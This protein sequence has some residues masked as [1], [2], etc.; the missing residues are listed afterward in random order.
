MNACGKSSAAVACVVLLSTGCSGLLGLDDKTFDGSGGTSGPSTTAA[1]GGAGGTGGTGTA[2]SGGST[3]SG[4][5]G[6]SGGASSGSGGVLAGLLDDEFDF[7]S[8][9]DPAAALG[10]RGW[11]FTR[12][13]EE[14]PAAAPYPS[15]YVESGKLQVALDKTFFWYAGGKG[16]LMYKEITGDFL[17]V[18]DSYSTRLNPSGGVPLDYQSGAGILARDPASAASAMGNQHWLAVDRGANAGVLRVHGTWTRASGAS[19]SLPADVSS[20]DGKVAMC[21]IGEAFAI[22]SKEGGT[23]VD[24]TSLLAPNLVDDLP[25]TLQVGL[26]AYAGAEFPGDSTPAGVLGR[27]DFVHQV[28]PGGDCNPAA[29]Q[30]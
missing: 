19:T 1:S 23:W 13:E 29:H 30:E 20:Q 6:G 18:A 22:W 5:V 24:R 25:A 14:Y 17:V 26:F 2:G 12:G 28:D 15:V 11:R 8:G 10:A 16:F 21:R 7:D 3:G 9:G 4:G 27:F